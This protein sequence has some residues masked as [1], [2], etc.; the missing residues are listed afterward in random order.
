M[1]DIDEIIERIK[2]DHPSVTVQQLKKSLPGDDD[3]LWYFQ[4]PESEFEVQI[5]SSTGRCPFLVET[6]ETADRFTGDTIE[7]TTELVTRL[8]R[9]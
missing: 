6:D 4:Q 8:L 7:R 2:R 5:E 1:R 3:G 9:L